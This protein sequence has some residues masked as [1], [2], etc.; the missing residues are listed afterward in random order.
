M[1]L[2]SFPLIAFQ[3]VQSWWA[4]PDVPIWEG[5][6]PEKFS[7]TVTVLAAL[8]FVMVVGGMVWPSLSSPKLNRFDAP[9]QALSL[10]INRTMDAREGMKR[11]SWWE[12]QLFILTAG[13]NEI[14]Q[15]SAIEWYQELVKSSADPLVPLQLAVIQAEAGHVSQALLSAYEWAD[16]EDPLP[17]FAVLMMAAYGDGPVY[18]P[19]RYALWETEVAKI[20]PSGWFYERL[21]ERLAQRAN[22]VAFLATIRGQSAG[23]V[24]R[25]FALSQRMALIELVAMLVG[26]IICILFW[27]RRNETSS[28]VRL[29][30]AGI[31]PRW[32]GGVGIAVLLRGGA[33][34]VLVTTLFLIYMRPENPALSMLVIFM[35]YVPILF[36]AYWHLFR[37]L[38]MS[39]NEGFGL[40]IGWAR[41]GSLVIIVLGV[42]AAGLW[43]EWMLNRVATFF[44]FTSHWTEW[45]D[46]DLVR[47]APSFVVISV[48]AYVIFAPLF[49]E[50]VFRGIL[51]AVLRRKFC[52]LP[53]ALF[54][55]SIFAIAHGYGL[56]GFISVFWS[57]VLWAWLYEKTGSLWPS[58]L[59][60]AIN[61]L[62]VCL[63]VLTLLR[64]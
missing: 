24:E 23:R 44:H 12:Q 41:C 31:P 6:Y 63:N 52:F 51:F 32:L 1:K 36:L 54:S 55:A 29:H 30:E 2:M 3:R 7:S 37:P 18:D 59:A 58:I 61:N 46:E 14:E 10:I 50:L 9:E 39:F 34:G 57:G 64:F 22:D 35:T 15:A 13:S 27:V 40:G 11:A 26:P 38:D 20:F 48:L 49:E 8:I 62:L 5:N 16:A 4:A 33:L 60:H 17:Q 19:S 42:L 45:F 56:L 25:Q 28:F 43:G 53:A 47:A 21:V